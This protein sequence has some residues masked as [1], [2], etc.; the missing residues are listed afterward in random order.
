MLRGW[1][2]RARRTK[3]KIKGMEVD[4]GRRT[5]GR[6]KGELQGRELN[7]L[8]AAKI[9]A[10]IALGRHDVFWVWLA[11]AYPLSPLPSWAH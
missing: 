5:E 3:G 11:P 9:N 1:L 8:A 10:K 2:P 6:G 7:L 4:R